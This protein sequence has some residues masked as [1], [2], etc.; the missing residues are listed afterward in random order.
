V[1]VYLSV[2]VSLSVCVCL[3]MLCINYFTVCV[4]LMCMSLSV[5]VCLSVC[6]S[7]NICFLQV[8]ATTIKL[9]EK[10]IGVNI[11]ET[12]SLESRARERLGRY[13]IKSTRDKRKYR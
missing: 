8:R 9:L 3:C 12:I 10:N 7:H 6:V 2:C 5:C 13:D 11:H 1:D 4:S